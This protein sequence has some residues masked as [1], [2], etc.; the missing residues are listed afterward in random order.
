VTFDGSDN[1]YNL[2][3]QYSVLLFILTFHWLMESIQIFLKLDSLFEAK[4][5]IR[6]K[7]IQFILNLDSL[8]KLRKNR[9]V[10][11]V[12]FRWSYIVRVEMYEVYVHMYVSTVPA[13][14]VFLSSYRFKCSLSCSLFFQQG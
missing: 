1:S 8:Q 9:S 4:L 13:S 3:G 2:I 14:S 7:T 5:N 10:G 6:A 11:N 12:G